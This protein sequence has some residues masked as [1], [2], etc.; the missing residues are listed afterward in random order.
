MLVLTRTDSLVSIHR[1]SSG[2]T[3][4]YY[5]YHRSDYPHSWILFDTTPRLPPIHNRYALD[6]IPTPES[7]DARTGR[8]RPTSIEIWVSY[9]S[10]TFGRSP[11]WWRLPLLRP[12]SLTYGEIRTSFRGSNCD[13]F[14]VT[15]VC[16]ICHQHS[17]YEVMRL[18]DSVFFVCCTVRYSFTRKISFGY[19]RVVCSC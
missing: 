6:D 1:P 18:F 3:I 15:T 5:Q 12:F 2:S 19:F 9:E 13:Y 16:K 10:P 7:H 8:T 17:G 11:S 4:L 14:T